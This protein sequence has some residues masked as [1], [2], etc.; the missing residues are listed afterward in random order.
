MYS[1]PIGNDVISLGNVSGD[2]LLDH[3]YENKRYDPP[4]ITSDDH[5]PPLNDSD[6]V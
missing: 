3:P 5:G 1:K 4:P 2:V 6:A